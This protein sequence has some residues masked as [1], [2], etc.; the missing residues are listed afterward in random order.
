MPGWKPLKGTEICDTK[1]LYR[2]KKLKR[3]YIVL[4]ENSVYIHATSKGDFSRFCNHSCNP[5]CYIDHWIV[6]SRVRMDI[7]SGEELCFHYN[8]DRNGASQQAC[9]CGELQWRGVAEYWLINLIF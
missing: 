6:K 3:T 7:C 8:M 4:L 1:K 9:H 5:N 2:Q